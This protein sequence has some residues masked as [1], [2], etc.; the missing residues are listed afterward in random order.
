MSNWADDV[1]DEVSSTGLNE[2]DSAEVNVIRAPCDRFQFKRICRNG[3]ECL[4]KNNGCNFF[5]HPK[6]PCP[7]GVSCDNQQCRTIKYH[8]R[9]QDGNTGAHGAPS[10][11]R[12]SSYLNRANQHG[13]VEGVNALRLEI[14]SLRDQLAMVKEEKK[15]LETQVE[16]TN[17]ALNKSEMEKRLQQAEFSA[18]IARL[19]LQ[20]LRAGN[21]AGTMQPQPKA[22]H[23]VTTNHTSSVAAVKR[24]ACNNM[25][26]FGNC[27]HGF[28][29]KFSHDPDYVAKE[30]AKLQAKA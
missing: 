27:T 19:E 11:S 30:K 13:N 4:Y 3:F 20:M 14:A 18:T 12:A 25:I 29:C 7:K 9:R 28:S 2:V 10:S 8:P 1:D 21:S 17:A 22:T 24:Y 23:S 26:R 6:E 16:A 15:L 5:H